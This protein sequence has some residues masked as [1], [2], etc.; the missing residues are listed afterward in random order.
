MCGYIFYPAL[1][2]PTKHNRLV[3]CIYDNAGTNINDT[4]RLDLPPLLH[5]PQPHPLSP[6]PFRRGYPRIPVVRKL[7]LMHL[8]FD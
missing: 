6:P 1:A 7:G 5:Q 3:P 4:E 8:L 2:V